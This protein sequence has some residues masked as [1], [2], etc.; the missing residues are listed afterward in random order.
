MVNM[1]S[2]AAYGYVGRAT[3]L[4]LLLCPLS[5]DKKKPA[6]STIE[7]RLVSTGSL[8]ESTQDMGRL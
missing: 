5:H 6:G 7:S 3:A 2:V 8:P 4:F 1:E